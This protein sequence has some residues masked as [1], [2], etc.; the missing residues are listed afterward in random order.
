MMMDVKKRMSPTTIGSEKQTISEA[1]K[2]SIKNVT[3]NIVDSTIAKAFL[4]IFGYFRRRYA[5]KIHRNGK[6]SINNI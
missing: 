3:P 1:I 5:I 4:V 6:P 2:V